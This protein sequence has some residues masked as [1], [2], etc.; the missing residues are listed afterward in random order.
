WLGQGWLR[1]VE[2]SGYLTRK[3]YACWRACDDP[4]LCTGIAGLAWVHGNVATHDLPEIGSSDDKESQR[5]Y[6]EKTGVSPQWVQENRGSKSV[7]GRSFAAWTIMVK[8]RPW[9]VMVLDSASPENIS[10]RALQEFQLT[11]PIF[12][13]L[14]ERV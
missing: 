10:S 1:P 13:R 8:Q 3:S 5:E 14:L 4:A 11:A 2:R 7:Q 9:G 12:A 6:A